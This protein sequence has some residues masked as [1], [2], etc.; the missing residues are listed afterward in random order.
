MKKELL[1]SSLYLSVRS[2]GI[3]PLLALLAVVAP[4]CGDRASNVITP[5]A[6]TTNASCPAVR[7]V[8]DEKAMTCRACAANDECGSSDR[9][10]CNA[11]QC[12]ECMGNGDCTG[13]IRTICDT[14][15]HRCVG[16]LIDAH[17]PFPGDICNP[18]ARSCT[19]TCTTDRECAID[20]PPFPFCDAGVHMCVEC[21][22]DS[23]CADLGLPYCRSLTCT[24]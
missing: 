1:L 21:R 9:P 13:P 19:I 10:F 17:C 3:A 8:C 2:A 6:C 20:I 18:V 16:C 23:E 14:A 7:P 12:V 15:A 11:G 4:A 24:R 22:E 5:A